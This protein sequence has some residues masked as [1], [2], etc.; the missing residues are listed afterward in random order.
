MFIHLFIVEVRLV[1]VPIQGFFVL[2]IVDVMPSLPSPL[3]S[4]ILVYDIFAGQGPAHLYGKTC[5]G[6]SVD[7]E[8]FIV[9]LLKQLTLT[10]PG[11][12]AKYEP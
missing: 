2:I 11:I 8:W 7:D 10:F 5:F 1:T 9:Y 4:Q 6:D 3:N 12:V